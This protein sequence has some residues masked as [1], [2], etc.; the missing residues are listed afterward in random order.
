MR[1]C[2]RR[3]VWVWVVCGLRCACVQQR[4]TSTSICLHAHTVKSF[5]WLNMPVCETAMEPAQIKAWMC[6]RYILS[7]ESS[8]TLNDQQGPKR[9]FSVCR[10]WSYPPLD[11]HASSQ[12]LV[13][14]WLHWLHSGDQNMH[15]SIYP[16]FRFQ[17]VASSLQRRWEWWFSSPRTDAGENKTDSPS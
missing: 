1:W 5:R 16:L 6:P 10:D 12:F 2:R 11:T 9:C 13:M 7:P 4:K 3:Y 17:G 15:L 8:N 14:R